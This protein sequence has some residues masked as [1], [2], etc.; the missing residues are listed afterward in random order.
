[1]KAQH[2]VKLS[3]IS[4][5]SFPLTALAQQPKFAATTVLQQS[6]VT[7]P[8][9]VRP[10]VYWYWMNDNVSAAG[11]KK[12]L[13]AMAEVGI[14]RAFIGNIGM[15][16]KE[17]PYGKAKLFSDEWYNVTQTA[18]KHAGRLGI[19]IGLF[20]SP[21]WS[22]SGGPWIKP[23][24]SMRYLAHSELR[25]KGG[26]KISQTIPAPGEH[27]QDVVTLAFPV[28]V[29]D[30]DDI[31]AH[32][33][34]LSSNAS[35]KNIQ[36][37]MDGNTEDGVDIEVVYTNNPVIFDIDVDK[38]FTARSL[39]MYPARRP[40][41]AEV[42]LQVQRGK[43]YDSIT[44]FTFDRTNPAR[45]VGFKPY[46]PVSIAFPAVA[47]KRFR[48]VLKNSGSTAFAEFKLLA[49]P[50]I[51][52]FEDKQLSKMFQT[53]LPLWK[54]YQW[55]QQAEPE[56]SALVIT[57]GKVRNI[58]AYVD[59]KGQLNW[60]APA[61]QW[62]V[63][64]YGMLPTNVTNA[65]ATP[66]GQGLE[67]DKINR[68]PVQ[69]HYDA[70]IGDI[71]KRIPAADRKA[72][73]WVVADSYET[74]SQNWTDDMAKAFKLQYGYDPVPWLPV[75]TGRIVNSADQ[76]NRFLWDLRRLVADRVATEYVG[77]LRQQSNKDGLKVWL[78]N[79]GHWGFPSEFLKYGSLADEIGGEFW[80]EGELGNIEC[81]A[82]SSSA[83]T[84]GKN[85]VSAES[86]TS[87]GDT[88]GR[89]PALLKKRGDWSFT[90]GINNT[91]LHVFISQPEDDRKPGINAWFGTEFNRNNTWFTQGKAFIDY[92]RRCNYLLQQG[93]P[94]NDIAYFIGEDAPK[95]TGVRMPELPAGYGY[96]YINAD[97]ILNRL[98]VKGNRLVLPE[99][100]S[101]RMLVLPELTTMRPELLQKIAKLVEQGAVVFGPAPKRSPSL[102]HYPVADQQIGKLAYAMWGSDR[103]L[104]KRKYGNGWL[105]NN[106]TMEQALAEIQLKPDVS[107]KN[108]D[109]LYA[110]RSTVEGDVYFLTNQT[111]NNVAIYPEFR[112]SGLQPEWWDAVSGAMRV[113]PEYT[114]NGK[115]TQVPIRLEAYESGFVVFRKPASAAKAGARNFPTPQVVQELRNPWEVK[116]ERERRGPS[117]TIDME[118]PA[119]WSQH[120]DSL[121]RH[122]AGSAVY[123]TS[124][125]I[126]ELPF[127]TSYIDLGKV[128]VMAKVKLNGVEVGTV[129]TP[130]Y[131][132]DVTAALKKGSN[133]LEVEVVNTWVNRL[134]GDSRLPEKDRKTW[135]NA[136]PYQPESKLQSAGLL[137]PVK[138]DVV[139]Y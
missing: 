96:D 28:P 10:S 36:G 84:Y 31:A 80:N 112:V 3:L 9:S 119:D 89:Y 105:L 47:G 138:L 110:H 66:E 60:D 17:I 13:D 91:L 106:M 69:Q 7:P 45:N 4:C 19:D 123:T 59:N 117:K 56:D 32:G 14:G 102:Q 65:P 48:L 33:A 124:F 134:I 37:L 97:V 98:S 87:A 70:F 92:I 137:G 22:Q 115:T 63:V 78:E 16:E 82:A 50:R 116:F 8:D 44:S 73:K 101:Y 58:S 6:F 24:Q 1:M 68:V 53:P 5:L 23:G 79:Y 88:Y 61:G 46:A 43:E 136:N 55:P 35:V 131:R 67:V 109:V 57:P 127:G 64:R 81:K 18:I 139:R 42:I 72:L 93:R 76:S 38:A 54:E 11:V 130:P 114:F 107:L 74:G 20:N 133:K 85:K 12:D 39:V 21:G 41:R 95:M 126:A 128:M 120:S 34:K 40:A 75:L 52:W 30:Q 83:H 2:M 100:V 29:G 26:G 86:F 71:R 90:E 113:L 15:S 99:G 121:I 49:A 129:W 135:L 125:S 118:Q 104:A 27:F 62:L 122:Y 111:D 25:V 77:G 103:T 51:E 94:V 132:V 108:K